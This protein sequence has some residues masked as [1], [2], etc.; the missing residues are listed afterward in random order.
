MHRSGYYNQSKTAISKLLNRLVLFPDVCGLPDSC[1]IPTGDRV[2]VDG[3]I[4]H[5]FL[6]AG[7]GFFG[8]PD[9]VRACVIGEIEHI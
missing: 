8:T 3:L 7:V 9:S 1:G 2:F 6:D 4:E 5:I